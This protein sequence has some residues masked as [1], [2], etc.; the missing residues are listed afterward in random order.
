MLIQIVNEFVSSIEWVFH[1]LAIILL[2]IL[3][4]KIFTF[5]VKSLQFWST[6]LWL[7]CYCRVFSQ[8]VW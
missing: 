3:I 1:N 5:Q 7:I 6:F 2:N 8:R 4:E